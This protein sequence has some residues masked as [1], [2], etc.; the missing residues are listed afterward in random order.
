MNEDVT[1]VVRRILRLEGFGVL[2]LAAHIYGHRDLGWLLWF[3]LF[4]VPDLSLLGYFGGN[5]WGARLYN[6]F[7]TYLSPMAL[8]AMGALVAEPLLVSLALIWGA[9][10]GLDRALGY[11]L[12]LPDGFAHTHLGTLGRPKGLPSAG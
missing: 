12:K 1:G 8:A 11:G 9:H 3:V 6:A 4:L 2:L 5:R 10:I 7:H